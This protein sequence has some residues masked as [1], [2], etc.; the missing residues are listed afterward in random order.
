VKDEK[1]ELV[2]R[3]IRHGEGFNGAVLWLCDYMH[4]KDSPVSREWCVEFV[5]GVI[6][7]INQEAKGE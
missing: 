7:K 3:A 5:R 6:V 2:R 4:E 1:E